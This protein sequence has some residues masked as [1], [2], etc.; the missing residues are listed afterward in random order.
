MTELVLRYAKIAVG[1]ILVWVLLHFWTSCSHK[2]ISGKEMA[3][4]LS[5]NENYW[6]LVKERTPDVLV[7][8]DIIA[9]EYAIP[10]SSDRKEVRAARIHAMPGQRVKIEKGELYLNGRKTAGVGKPEEFLEEF[11]VPNGS[12]F[13]L[14]D[15]KE[16]GPQFDS[17][18][19]GPLG[20]GAVL[21]KVK[22]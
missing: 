18:A 3:P 17:R 16:S 13:V 5:P 22:K 21:G 2:K 20:V 15:N 10:G 9:F 1:F 12:Y 7:P 4:A 8:G 6:V 19:I 11:I 14:M